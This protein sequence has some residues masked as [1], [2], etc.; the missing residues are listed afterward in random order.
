MILDAILVTDAPLCNP[1]SGNFRAKLDSRSQ[2][3]A[4][5]KSYNSISTNILASC[6]QLHAEGAHLFYGRNTFVLDNDSLEPGVDYKSA[7]KEHMIPRIAFRQIPDQYFTLIKHIK[8][9]IPHARDEFHGMALLVT[10]ALSKLPN[11]EKM[12]IVLGTSARRSL[13]RKWKLCWHND[14]E[15]LRRLAHW[16]R[17]RFGGKVPEKLE[18]S[19]EVEDRILRAPAPYVSLVQQAWNRARN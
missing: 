13:K 2:C 19:I 7:M 16:L 10:L 17:K 1:Q 9:D 11:V 5:D 18:V 4:N 15:K 3:N 6:R 12:T 8:V 14:S